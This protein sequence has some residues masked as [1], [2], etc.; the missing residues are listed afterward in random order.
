M[1]QKNERPEEAQAW[2]PSLGPCQGMQH[3]TLGDGDWFPPPLWHS[4]V[5]ITLEHIALK[6]WERQG[7]LRTPPMIPKSSQETSKEVLWL[8][9][10]LMV[11]SPSSSSCRS[12]VGSTTTPAQALPHPGCPNWGRRFIFSTPL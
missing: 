3:L 6:C 2:S 12:G 9:G 11:L 10:F 1:R 7:P 5:P 8:P 4:H